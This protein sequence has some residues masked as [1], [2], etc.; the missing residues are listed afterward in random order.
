M[1]GL[2]AQFVLDAT[3]LNA[4]RSRFDMVVGDRRRPLFFSDIAALAEEVGCNSD[5]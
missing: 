4:C 2:V 3:S 1:H 5:D